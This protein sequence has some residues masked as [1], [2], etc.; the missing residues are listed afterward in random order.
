[1][2]PLKLIHQTMMYSRF[3]AYAGRA[4]GDYYCQSTDLLLRLLNEIACHV[5]R[6]LQNNRLS[7]K[8]FRET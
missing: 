7:S 5:E 2:K 3:P 8:G 1:M 4:A 6:F